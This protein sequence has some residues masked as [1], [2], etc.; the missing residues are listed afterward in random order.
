MFRAPPPPPPTQH[1]AG[2]K[3]ID[4]ALDKHFIL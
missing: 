2:T 1:V 4:F 3:E